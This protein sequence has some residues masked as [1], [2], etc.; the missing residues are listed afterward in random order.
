MDFFEVVHTQRAIR[1]FKPDPVSEEALWTM[2]DAAIRAPSGSNSQPW[3][4]LVV[5]NRARREVI[6]KAVRER[7]VTP[8]FLE[9]MRQMAEKAA[10]P[11][12]RRMLLGAA[13]FF[14]DVAAA[15]VLLIPCL[16]QIS[17]PTDDPRG[18]LAGSS[19][20]GAVQNL[21]LAGRALGIGTV[22]TTF[23]AGMEDMLRKE[24]HLPEDAVPTC[25]VAVGYPDSQRFGPT[26]RKPVDT[27][28]YWD[29]W[30]VARRRV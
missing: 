9:Q 26:T 3:R 22:L 23:H 15:P 12:E 2:L 14:R 30:G 4:W 8:D 13:D 5:R 10:S 25:V 29:D 16:Y 24:F 19:I 1:R 11:T 18:L 7:F 6:S 20:Y 28:T 21:L 27:V 17:S